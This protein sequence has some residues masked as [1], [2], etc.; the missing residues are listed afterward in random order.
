MVNPGVP[1][2]D[3]PPEKNLSPEQNLNKQKEDTRSGGY[4]GG[5]R[6]ASQSHDDILDMPVEGPMIPTQPIERKPEFKVQLTP[7]AN[8]KDMEELLSILNERGLPAALRELDRIK[9][10]HLED[11]FHNLLTSMRAEGTSI[12]GLDPKSDIGRALDFTVLEVTVPEMSGNHGGSLTDIVTQMELLYQAVIPFAGLPDMIFFKDWRKRR[13]IHKDHFTMELAVSSAEEDAVFYV[14]VPRKRRELFEKQIHAHFHDAHVHELKKDYNP[15]NQFGVT[16]IAYLTLYRPMCLPIRTADQ[17]VNDPLNQLLAV[18]SRMSK[19]G[20]GA[21]LQ[22]SVASAGEYW[23]KRFKSVLDDLR[24][25]KMSGAEV[26]RK[27]RL[28]GRL[29]FMRK[30]APKF[31]STVMDIFSSKEKKEKDYEADAIQ[32]NQIEK[33]MRSVISGVNMRFVV[34]ARTAQR[35]DA[36]MHEFELVLNQ[37]E[38]I[39]GNRFKVRF[40]KTARDEHA[41]LRSFIFRTFDPGPIESFW[42][43][44]YNEFFEKIRSPLLY[45]SPCMPMN[46]QE[47]ATVFHLAIAGGTTSREA[48]TA[49]GKYAPA[50]LGVPTSGVLLGRNTHAGVTVDIRMTPNDRLRHLYV[51]G[52]TGT[53]KTNFLKNLIIQ[54]IENGEGVCFVDPHGADVIDIL[55][56]IPK[57]RYDDVIYFDP[58]FTDR[59]MGLNMLEYDPRF[60]E[61]KTFVV[62]ELFKI[63]QKL[64]GQV[65]EAFGPIFEQ[66]FRNAA[67]LVVED[68][69][70]GSTL[71]DIARVLSD[72]S[73]RR[74]KL[75][76]CKNEVVSHFWEDIAERV[77][78][79]GSLK[80]IVPYI[81]SKFDIFIANEI[82]RPI[83][84]QQRSS[85]NFK[86]IMDS[87]KIFLVNL[88]KGRLGDQNAN[89]IGLIIV[90]KFLMTALARDPSKKPPPFY[91]YLD[92]FQNIST[93]SISTILAEARKFGLSL[94][95]AHQFLGQLYPRIRDA[96]FGNVGSMAVFRVG[97]DDAEFLS[98]QLTPIFSPTD[99]LKIPNF[100]AYVRLL[101]NNSPLPPF[102]LDALP[103]VSGDAVNI[104]TLKQLSFQRFGR[105]RA[106]VEDEIR[107]KYAQL[108]K[109]L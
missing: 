86:D 64:Y 91:L 96:V 53:G 14:A 67:L 79:E 109:Q 106:A 58:A 57:E 8:D 100:S 5:R 13:A 3:A 87:K 101:A 77:S 36:L 80:N 74:L 85:F 38:D 107:E 25:G 48:K 1:S 26:Y 45:A 10:P 4:G 62:D 60:P 73:Y 51:I 19:E 70:T 102:T 15:F 105:P 20:E 46:L 103:Y 35:A 16:R 99:V 7:E 69:D 61:Q 81:T 56:R 37:F 17:F 23:T 66:Y 22:F 50:P 31:L 44:L 92:E 59:P 29:S 24:S 39:Q 93:D 78:G 75:S 89:L 90:G 34:S 84:G 30:H 41:L 6:G 33:K 12:P 21:A 82:M 97:P 27:H 40:P 18:M 54:D 11:D 94:T 28:L 2:F 72:E 63:F 43:A 104:E 9:N 49:G 98:K 71:M 76:R 68:P 83:V 95:M 65:P 108:K 47:L 32:V 88:S 42:G 55:S 52:Q